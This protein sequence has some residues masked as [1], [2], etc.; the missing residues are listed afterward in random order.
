[1]QIESK[2]QVSPSLVLLFSFFLF[3][4]DLITLF[5][6][7]LF[8]PARTLCGEK[9]SKKNL[10]SPQ[11]DIE[12]HSMIHGQF[13]GTALGRA[14]CDSSSTL[15][16]SVFCACFVLVSVIHIISFVI[17]TNSIHSMRQMASYSRNCNCSALLLN[18]E[19]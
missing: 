1:M 5:L 17:H 12:S 2:L 4:L 3:T 18:R 16:L 10:C 11:A 7:L 6:E 13:I 19:I 14:K 15:F 9:H 8:L